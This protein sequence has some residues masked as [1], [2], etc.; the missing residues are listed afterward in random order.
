ML[1]HVNLLVNPTGVKAASS[2]LACSRSQGSQ[3]Q[4]CTAAHGTKRSREVTKKN[5]LSENKSSFS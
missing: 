1:A 2:L 5:N 4:R 3:K